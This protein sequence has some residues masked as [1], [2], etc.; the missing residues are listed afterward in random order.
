MLWLL[1]ITRDDSPAAVVGEPDE[2]VAAPE[3]FGDP[4]AALLSEAEEEEEEE[5]EKD[6]SNGSN[7]EHACNNGSPSKLK[8]P[9]TEAV[10]HVCDEE[11]HDWLS[12]QA[13]VSIRYAND[14]TG[15]NAPLFAL[16]ELSN[17]LEDV[18]G[19]GLAIT[20]AFSSEIG[21]PEGD[22]AR[23]FLRANDEP[24][25]LFRDMTKRSDVGWCDIAQ[26]WRTVEGCDIY[27]AGTECKDASSANRW[28][29][30]ID[31]ES[32]S[33]RTSI[34]MAASFDYVR[35][36]EP[37]IVML[38]EVWNTAL[39]HIMQNNMRSIGKYDFE[40]F[41]ACPSAWKRRQTRRRIIGIGVNLRKATLRKPVAKW[42]PFVQAVCDAMV[43]EDLDCFLLQDDDEYLEEVKVEMCCRRHGSSNDDNW[44]NLHASNRS[45]LRILHCLDVPEPLQLR[46]EMRQIYTLGS[47]YLTPREEDYFNLHAWI[48]REVC[49]HSGRDDHYMWDVSVSDMYP[50]NKNPER[51]GTAPCFLCNHIVVDTKKDRPIFGK[52]KL[53]IH[54]FPRH[55]KTGGLDDQQL[56][57]LAGNT[58]TIE[59][60]GTF[61]AAALLHVRFHAPHGSPPSPAIHNTGVLGK[62]IS[63]G[64]PTHAPCQEWYHTLPKQPKCDSTL[65][66]SENRKRAR[67]G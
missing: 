37:P 57:Q 8:R 56:G 26:T 49:G 55:V 33:G 19:Q 27:F 7:D 54:G 17:S 14:C 40:V 42:L 32:S 22:P 48:L 2:F 5:E 38:E 13:G 51:C 60:V 66:K 15:A 23:A 24:E 65:N 50:A 35:K 3:E 11:D 63:V 4:L 16:Q 67:A 9:W 47:L 30:E 20:H 43:E 41:G 52:E 61:L 21:G 31:L 29:V 10:W 59:V 46:E 53:F 36:E 58:V 62:A 44:H 34:T 45:A 12:R 6:D 18:A 25:V 64:I 28:P 1:L 39:I